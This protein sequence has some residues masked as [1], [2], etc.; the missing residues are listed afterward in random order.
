MKESV[1]GP[2]AG[3]HDVLQ[4]TGQ[5][6]AA[7]MLEDRDIDIDIALEQFLDHVGFLDR[8]ALRDFLGDVRAGDLRYR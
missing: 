5:D 7:V 1:G 8:E 2:A 4:T 6:R 3:S